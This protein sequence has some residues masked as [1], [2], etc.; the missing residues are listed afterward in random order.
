MFECG[1]KKYLG[2][3]HE[4]MDGE[5]EI[6]ELYLKLPMMLPRKKVDNN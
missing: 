2:N 4:D 6:V 5:N 3:V 1:V